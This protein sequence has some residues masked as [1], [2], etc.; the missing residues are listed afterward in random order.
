MLLIFIWFAGFI[1]MS[2]YLGWV[3][4]TD[5]DDAEDEFFGVIMAALW[6]LFITYYTASEMGDA[7]AKLVRKARVLL[8][9]GA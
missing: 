4:G 1:I 7:A 6:P 3:C 9:R 5:I 8:R 2:F